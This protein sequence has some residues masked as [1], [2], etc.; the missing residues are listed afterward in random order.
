MLR[1]LCLL[2]NANAKAKAASLRT[3]Q[4]QFLDNMDSCISWE[5]VTLDLVNKATQANH[6]GNT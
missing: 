4:Q 6:Y 1:E 2:T 5:V 3:T